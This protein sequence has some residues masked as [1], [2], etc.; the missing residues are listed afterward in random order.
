MSTKKNKKMQIWEFDPVLYPYRV[1]I[2]RHPDADALENKYNIINSDYEEKL[3]FLEF[4]TNDD[5]VARVLM[6]IDKETRKVYYMVLLFAVAHARAGV[7]AH[8]AVHLAN[9]YLQRLGF[10]SPAAYNDEPYAYFVE[11]ITDCIWCVLVGEAEAM[12]GTEV[13]YETA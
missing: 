10:G 8:E 9:A 2:V 13:E 4:R 5:T 3:P 6:V 7:M 1:L 12:K 11:W